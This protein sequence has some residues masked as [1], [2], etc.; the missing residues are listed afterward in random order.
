MITGRKVWIFS[1][2]ALLLVLLFSILSL[3]GLIIDYQWFKELGYTQVFFT[4]FIAELKIGIPVFII[5]FIIMYIYLQ[6]I[7]RDFIKF[8]TD[9]SNGH[10]FRGYNFA[11]IVA[12]LIISL[13]SSVSLANNLWSK[14]LSYFNSVNFNINDPLFKKDISLYMFK[15]PF[16]KGVF[17]FITVL[18]FI[19]AIITVVLYV[20]MYLSDS[21]RFYRLSDDENVLMAYSNKDI[22]KILIRRIA[23]F[24][25]ILFVL[26]GVGYYF[27]AFDLVY[28][29]RGV[30]FGAGYTDVH[31]TLFAYRVLM[32]VSVLAGMLFL[33]GALMR[34]LKII[35]IGPIVM[36][37]II[38]LSGIVSGIVQQLIVSP[39]ELTKE[40][41]YIK[42][43]IEY[44]QKGFG[45]D[46]VKRIDFNY[47]ESLTAKSLEEEK[48]TIE[49]IRIN[50]YRPV[51]QVYNQLQ[52]IRLYY[53]F[54][55]IDI[56]R[57]NIS[58]K[59]TQV[60]LSAREMSIPD[61]TDQA[62]TWINEHLKYT[63]GYGVVMSPVNSVNSQGQPI[64]YIKDI[65]PV[66]DNNVK[67][68]RPEIYFGELTNNYV[69]TNTALKE[70]DYPSG[71]D[72]VESVYKG[73]AGIPMN[74]LNRLLFAV[75][76]GDIKLLVS[77]EIKSSSRILI[78][79]NIMERVEKIAPF[80]TYDQDPYIVIDNGKLYWMI[81]AFT[82][83]DSYPYS[84]PYEFFDG[85]RINYIRNSVKVVV[86]AY[87]GSVDYYIVDK[88]DPVA[89]VYKNIFPE[90]FK[91]G[92]KMPEGL[93]KHIR[94]PQ[95]LFD[96]QAD[97]YR[98]Y[99]MSNPT[100]F[101]NREDYYDIAKEKYYD[102]TQPEESQYMIAKLPGMEKEEYVLT[103]PFTPSQKDNLVAYMVARMDGSNYGKLETYVM[104][105]GMT[106]YGPMQ[107]EAK[108]DN[109]PDISKE[110]SLWDQKGSQVLRGN[111][112]A[113][114]IRNSI[115][116]VE[117]LY[118]KSDA[119]E[120]IPEVKR[121]IVAYD[122]KIV[123][124]ETL[125][126]A[127]N[128]IFN[129]T[130][131][132]P[133][134]NNNQVSA[135]PTGSV[136]DLIRQ[137]NDLYQKADSAIKAGDWSSYGDYIKRLGDILKALSKTTK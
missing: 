47:R 6:K 130:T 19:L 94:Y 55:D 116:Y 51:S 50:D 15:L 119:R 89:M 12:S 133:Q 69:I 18:L 8:S 17:S 52:G 115:L 66:S 96:L 35:A 20:L 1:V 127:L 27:K 78:Y 3:S 83:S 103:I 2:I 28:S 71:A 120:S 93:K 14:A 60:F 45:L 123:M 65:P 87:N 64:M 70:F 80:L 67:V 86:D 98:N 104:P 77:G 7:K 58:G 82:T 62:K 36:V 38:V 34:N 75:N 114:P 39:N 107:I 90:L 100:V 16:I 4:R 110:L 44:T 73:K 112:L 125:N 31:V 135:L 131:A 37:V 132:T 68:T 49:N 79:R 102:K 26:F 29:S 30:V 111:T 33:I 136:Q 32:V 97:V 101:Y 61:L 108:I 24:G 63:H 46:R 74:F 105:K 126:A 22:L 128:K 95:D 21:T 124:E 117:P 85:Q 92:S 42:Y 11:I 23:V 121:V 106:I 25:F 91:D 54:N 99:H 13:I 9:Y 43:N 109:N 41:P 57:Y 81:D 40:M 84:Q 10:E 118:I 56:D 88:S 122:N 137:A 76:Y 134:P 72:N 53:K 48:N 59:Y 113:I 5:V 129:I